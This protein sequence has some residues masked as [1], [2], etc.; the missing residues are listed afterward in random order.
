[1]STYPP[2]LIGGRISFFLFFFTSPS[3]C[4]T[5]A[6]N[7]CVR[8]I[9]QPKQ[10]AV[11]ISQ[12]CFRVISATLLG[13]AEQRDVAPR[14]FGGGAGER[15]EGLIKQKESLFTSVSPRLENEARRNM[16]EIVYLIKRGAGGRRGCVWMHPCL[17]CIPP[18]VCTYITPEF[19]CLSPTI[20]TVLCQG[21]LL[22]PR[23]EPYQRG[24]HKK[25]ALSRLRSFFMFDSDRWHA[26]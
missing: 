1:M 6:V 8:T 13:Y 21:N 9:A 7:N 18:C 26:T 22:R 25:R 12:K 15:W 2:V 20:T 4:Y 3:D 24:K 11:D 5:G 23:V 17:G 14:E 10:H 16:V 19:L